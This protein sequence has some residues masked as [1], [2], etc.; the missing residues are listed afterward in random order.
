MRLRGGGAAPCDKVTRAQPYLNC[1]QCGSIIPKAFDFLKK[2]IFTVY[3][4]EKSKI[5]LFFY[6]FL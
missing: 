3:Y 5:H 4:P 2:L 6:F 1:A